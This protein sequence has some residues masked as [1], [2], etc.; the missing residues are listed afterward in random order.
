MRVEA[1]TRSIA[2]M[3]TRRKGVESGLAII[4]LFL[5]AESSYRGKW[6]TDGW[7]VLF[8]VACV[9]CYPVKH[10]HRLYGPI[11]AS[12][13][14]QVPPDDPQ[15]PV[16]FRARTVSQQCAQVFRAGGGALPCTV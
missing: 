6:S 3:L 16:Q 4:P 2:R 7:I 9:Q 12:V 14:L 11:P 13:S 10:W 5:L 8:F 15:N 1:N